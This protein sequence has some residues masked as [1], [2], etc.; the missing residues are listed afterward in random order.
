MGPATGS[1][2]QHLKSTALGNAAN[3]MG[4]L[5]HHAPTTDGSLAICMAG[6]NCTLVSKALCESIPSQHHPPLDTK[7]ASTTVVPDFRRY[8]EGAGKHHHA[9][10]SDKRRHGKE[11]LCQTIRTCGGR[12]FDG[13][14]HW[15]WRRPWSSCR[16]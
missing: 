4:C 16:D 10:R 2:I 7:V 14:V 3:M 13:D 6:G 12:S 8:S 1:G 9:Y 15:K 11:V 5:E